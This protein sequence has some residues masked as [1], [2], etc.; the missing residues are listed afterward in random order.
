M[1]L[2][3]ISWDDKWKLRHITMPLLQQRTS[4]FTIN[5]DFNILKVRKT[6]I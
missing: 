2:M 3:G 5:F 4:G 6:F 1:Y